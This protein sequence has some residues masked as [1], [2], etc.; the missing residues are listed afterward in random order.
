M[1]SINVALDA[2]YAPLRPLQSSFRSN[3]TPP[4]TAIHKSVC[5]GR[6][7]V[8]ALL[9][10]CTDSPPKHFY[11]LL[12]P[13]CRYSR[14][15][16]LN[17]PQT[18]LWFTGLH[19]PTKSRSRKTV[20]QVSSFKRFDKFQTVRQLIHDSSVSSRSRHDKGKTCH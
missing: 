4:G 9:P 10:F 11:G 5:R 16:V 14:A 3:L 13:C 17:L 6:T 8:T 15:H 18:I 19:L 12:A 2:T 1:L 20:R 7:A